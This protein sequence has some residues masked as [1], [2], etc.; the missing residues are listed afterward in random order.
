MIYDRDNDSVVVQQRVLNWT[1]IAFPGG[2]VEPGESFMESAIREVLEETGLTVADLKPC[3][4]VHW[5]HLDN[6]EKYLVYLYRTEQ[7]SGQMLS[8]TKEGKVY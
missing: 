7:F 3:G 4:I 1:G 5:D 6:G 2:H 8:E